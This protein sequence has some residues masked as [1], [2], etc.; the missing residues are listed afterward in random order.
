MS[1]LAE[2]VREAEAGERLL[3]TA[4]RDELVQIVSECLSGLGFQAT[5]M[6]DLVD[7]S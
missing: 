4:Q 2:A 6:D 1:L 7:C 5:N 3:L